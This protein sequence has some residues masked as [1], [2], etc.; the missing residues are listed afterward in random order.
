MRPPPREE[1][2]TIK[3][4]IG[5]WLLWITNR[6]S[7]VPPMTMSNAERWDAMDLFR[8]LSIHMLV[9]FDQAQVKRIMA[10]TGYVLSA[11][12]STLSL[13]STKL[14]SISSMIMSDMLLRR[15]VSN[16]T[17][18]ARCNCL[19]HQRIHKLRFNG[20]FSR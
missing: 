17:E 7:Q 15:L 11:W 8:R 2:R 12:L 9:S 14:P 4:E 3:V 13:S 16:C 19:Q 20:H 1:G 18:P 5:T 10:S 6:K